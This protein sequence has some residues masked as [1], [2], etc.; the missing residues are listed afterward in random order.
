MRKGVPTGPAVPPASS[1]RPPASSP[2]V[3]PASSLQSP[4][5]SARRWLITPP[6]PGA[7]DLAARLRTGELMAQL[8]YNRGYGDCDQARGYLAPK[9]SDLHDPQ[10]LSGCEAAARKIFQAVRDGTKIILYGDYDVDGMTGLAILYRALKRLNAQVDYYIPHRIEEG[11]GLNTPALEELAAKGY[12]L[13]ITVDCGIRAL[14]PLERAKELDLATIVTDHHAVDESLPPADI[15]VHPGLANYPNADLCG[16][17]VALKLAWELCRAASGQR[18]VSE[19][20]KEFLL[21]ATCLA[22]LGT[23]ADVVPLR[24]ENRVLATFGLKG[25]TQTRHPG[26]RALIAASGLLGR[27]V[28]AYDVGFGLAPVSTPP[29]AW[30]TPATRRSF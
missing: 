24:G 23:I 21:D 30:A 4:A 8:L 16:S 17:G 5:S 27:Q 2:A 18:R 15:V 25:L 22:A 13:L 26:L 29:G 28:G 10:L 14:K 9:L 12:G 7:R 19:D 1:L 20:L 6:W 11:Y 3:P